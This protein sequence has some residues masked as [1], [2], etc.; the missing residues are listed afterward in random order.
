MS[1]PTF[2]AATGWLN[3]ID[4]GS[5][6]MRWRYKSPTPLV[7]GVTLTASNLV[8]T[9]DTGGYVNALDAQS[10]KLLLHLN[11]N[12]TVQG[13]VVTYTAKDK[14]FIAVVSGDGGVINKRTFPEVVGGN[15][16][17]T[18]LGLPQK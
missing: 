14:Q 8:F 1:H 11:L 12:D 15:P 9:G 16:M 18:I 10:G 7:A 3:A 6:K 4:A 5:G 13:G 17:V 2:S